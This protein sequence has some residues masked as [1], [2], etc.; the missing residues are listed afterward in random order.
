MARAER[1]ERDQND[2]AACRS[3]RDV[4]RKNDAHALARLAG[5]INLSTDGANAGRLFPHANVKSVRPAPDRKNP[6]N[7]PM[8]SSQRLLSQ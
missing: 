2:G 3:C 6:E 5:A 4:R 7:N 1:P 8:H